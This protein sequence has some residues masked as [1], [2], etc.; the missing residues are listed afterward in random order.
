M[1]IVQ[2]IAFKSCKKSVAL[3]YVI[4]TYSGITELLFVE[5]K[6]KKKRK[7]IM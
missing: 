3:C 7:I 1:P 2:I 4:D 6:I 5:E